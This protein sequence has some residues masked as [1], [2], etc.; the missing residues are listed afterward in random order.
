MPNLL[1]EKFLSSLTKPEDLRKLLSSDDFYSNLESNIVDFLSDPSLQNIDIK[2]KPIPS[3]FF[4]TNLAKTKKYQFV[5]KL[6]S[7]IF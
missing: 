6:L 5:N 7:M 3:E 4:F 1:V 2:E